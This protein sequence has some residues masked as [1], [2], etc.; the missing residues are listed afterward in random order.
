[1]KIKDDGF[2]K[3]I[4]DLDCGSVFKTAWNGSGYFLMTD[5]ERKKDDA[6]MW[7]TLV[8]DLSDGHTNW[9]NNDTVIA[10]IDNAQL[11]VG[12]E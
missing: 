5:Q 2:I 1:M 10:P 11:V 7:E 9:M 4:G 3:K 6:T 8:V 12:G